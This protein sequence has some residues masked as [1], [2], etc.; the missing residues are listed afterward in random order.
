MLRQNLQLADLKIS[1]LERS[2]AKRPLLLLHGMADCAVVWS[3]L[4][5][6]LAPAYH[7]VAPDLRG[8]GESSKPQTDY[9]FASTIADLEALTDSLGWD[10]VDVV[11]HSWSA[12]LLTIWAT[13]SPDRFGSLVLVDPFF[14]N[15][16]P[17]FLKITFPF[18]YR[19]LPFL[20]AMGPF[21]SRAEAE[22]LAKTLKQ[23]RNWS[24]LQ[25]QAFWAGIEAKADGTW[26]SKFTREARNEIF[27]EVM[28][29]AGL[30]EP[31][32]LPTLL[33]VP[34]RGLNRTAWQIQPFKTY[35]PNLHICRISGNH[36]TFLVD[37]EPF[38]E[39]VAQFLA[40]Q[41]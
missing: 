33:I 14:I 39:I 17:S 9:T 37:P 1:Y 29:V 2:D 20:K 10:K 23:Y 25:Q 28:R 6:R 36:W 35:L 7:V 3:S 40:E 8:H 27:A 31:I 19:V 26:G 11:A 38:N 5:A 24:D 16:I 12:K 34:E 22:K 41:K 4:A 30:S 15:K 13:R 21:A 18:F 32:D